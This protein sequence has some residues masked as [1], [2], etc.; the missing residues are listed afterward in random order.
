M[1][2]SGPKK[3]I[4]EFDPETE[5]WTVIGAMKE[6]R[7]KHDVSVVSFADSDYDKLCN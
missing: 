5:S 1:P 4:S 2:N 6:K 7:Y 3:E